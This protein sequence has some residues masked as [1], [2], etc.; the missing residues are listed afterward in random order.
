MPGRVDMSTNSGS[1]GLVNGTLGKDTIM[2]GT[3]SVADQKSA[4]ETGVGL[5]GPVNGNGI[6]TNG[7]APK[8]MKSASSEP[9]MKQSS[10]LD[11]PPEILEIT[12]G[13]VS[14]GT[15]TSRVTQQAWI[16]LSELVEKVASMPS[17]SDR[18]LTNGY[19]N[20]DF[21]SSA[22]GDNNV[23]RK[24]L[25]LNWAN[26]TREKM[27]KLMVLARW[28]RKVDQI[29]RMIDLM[30][31]VNERDQAMETAAEGLGQLKLSL[32]EFKMRN[33][34]IKTSLEILSTG[35]AL[36]IPDFNLLP[37]KKLTPQT[38][39][40][41]LKEMDSLLSFRLT[42]HEEIPSHLRDWTI[43][44]GR[45]TFS[46][47]K[48]FEFDL[49]IGSEDP[50]K[51]LYFLDLRFLFSPVP[52]LKDG[53]ARNAL[54]FRTDELLRTSGIGG[55]ADFL[56]NFVMTQQ[57]SLLHSQA[58]DLQKGTWA[59]SLRVDAMH[60]WLTIQY[61]ARSSFPKSWIEI[62]ISSEE[63]TKT[64]PGQVALPKLIAKWKRYGVETKT[65]DVEYLFPEI[66]LEKLLK[67]IIASHAT[68]ILQATYDRLNQ[69]G[70]GSRA[71][72]LEFST[73]EFSTGDCFFKFRLGRFSQQITLSIEESSGNLTL[74]PTSI[75][76][77]LAERDLNSSKN[78]ILD[79]PA[80][81]EAYICDELLRTVESHAHRC[82][83]KTVRKVR[84]QAEHVAEIFG[85]KCR[86]V[87]FNLPGWKE[88]DWRLAVTVTLQGDRWWAVQL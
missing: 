34:D 50:A 17:N 23:T 68:G 63:N 82:S 14:L 4:I 6:M 73:S 62:G 9:T 58:R 32:H 70:N 31:W 43:A 77:R 72:A 19:A 30:F 29:K 37:F 8:Q 11:L 59:F 5:G 64:F 15:L 87:L 51:Q 22:S 28:S 1:H 71:L 56:R 45:A 52:R 74:T 42:L 76:A 2:S 3:T 41:T 69:S 27:I 65:P 85:S 26:T 38:M 86:Y 48:E 12:D 75:A 13:Y 33:P 18:P 25:W 47:P 61:W 7:Q 36:W 39:L 66:S 49:S 57:I 35:K 46:F 55:C 10:F 79:A 60:R 40:N 78:P 54:R 53:R 84:F 67:R 81:I 24:L 88:S 21:G 16:E 80:R 44:N 83:W 20:G